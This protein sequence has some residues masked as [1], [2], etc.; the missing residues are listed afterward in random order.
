MSPW[1]HVSILS[2]PVVGRRFYGSEPT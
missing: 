2:T 1:N